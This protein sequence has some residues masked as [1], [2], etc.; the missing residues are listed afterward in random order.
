MREGGVYVYREVKSE[1]IKSLIRNTSWRDEE[2]RKYIDELI[3]LERY[4]LEGVKGYA[5]ALHYGSL[6]QRYR[7]EWEKIYSELKPEEFEELMKREEEERKRKK[8]EDD[9]RRA[10]EIKEMERRKREWLEMGGLE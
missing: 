9:L 3:L 5:S 10:E 2:R 7:E 6:K 4:I 8:L 1:F